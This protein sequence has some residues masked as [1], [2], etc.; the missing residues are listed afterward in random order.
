MAEYG[1]KAPIRN[2]IAF[3]LRPYYDALD[4]GGVDI[5]VYY[6]Y[7]AQGM[8]VLQ[9]LYQEIGRCFMDKKRMSNFDKD[10]S[11]MLTSRRYYQCKENDAG[12]PTH[13]HTDYGLL[14]LAISDQPGLEVLKNV[15]WIAAPCGTPL[16]RFYVNV[17]DWL[18]FQLNN[19]AFIPG[20]HRVPNVMAQRF[21]VL[22]FLNPDN[23][24]SIETTNGMGTFQQY[25]QQRS[26]Y[27]RDL[28]VIDLK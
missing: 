3:H 28:E 9:R 15:D 5:Q 10:E 13:A 26:I 23:N 27:R 17:G 14:T 21:S 1:S 20:I 7:Y 12:I 22:L 24:D 6:D 4:T 19:K 8:L 18:L 11:S 25:A 16:P 2:Q